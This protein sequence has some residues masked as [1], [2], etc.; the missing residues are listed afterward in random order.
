ML[1]PAGFTIDRMPR[2]V[3]LL[4]LLALVAGGCKK[5]P[6]PEAPVRT[7]YR[8]DFAPADFGI[9]KAH[10]RDSA[11]NREIDALLEPVRLCYN[12]RRPEAEC[13]ALQQANS[14][15]IAR[16]RNALRCQR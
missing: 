4:L 14:E 3:W 15:K 5:A 11:C 8:T 10:T 2:P 6:P 16:I 12:N 9:G 1:P 13:S 7:P